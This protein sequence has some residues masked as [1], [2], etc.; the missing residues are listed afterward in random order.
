MLLGLGVRDAAEFRVCL[1]AQGAELGAL[2][3]RGCGLQQVVVDFDGLFVLALGREELGHGLGLDAG[4]DAELGDFLGVEVL[5]GLHRDVACGQDF[6]IVT[7]AAGQELG[8]I[9]AFAVGVALQDEGGHGEV[10]LPRL[11]KMLAQPQPELLVGQQLGEDGLGPADGGALLPFLAEQVDEIELGFEVVGVVL[12]AALHD[13][14]GPPGV[15]LLAVQAGQG[16]EYFG[17]GVV[18]QELVEKGES[19]VHIHFTMYMISLSAT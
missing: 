15:T 5:F 3:V 2:R 19:V 9:H 16:E 11:E 10:R 1:V 7:D 8:Q 13:L 4:I 17:P 12:D 14:D 6:G 18:F